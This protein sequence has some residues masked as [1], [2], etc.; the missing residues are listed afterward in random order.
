MKLST[1][2]LDHIAKTTADRLICTAGLKN[3]KKIV[4]KVRKILLM[5]DK[6]RKTLRG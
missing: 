2:E 1:V 4:G 3:A 5:E 6:R